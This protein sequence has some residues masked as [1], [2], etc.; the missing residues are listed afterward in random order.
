MSSSST[1]NQKPQKPISL[2]LLDSK[3]VLLILSVFL[4]TKRFEL[5]QLI[6]YLLVFFHEVLQVR[7]FFVQSKLHLVSL[8]V[9]LDQSISSNAEISLQLPDTILV[10]ALLLLEGSESAIGS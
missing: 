5:S 10:H 6:K 2:T 7:S 9:D 1:K 3:L 8:V 4:N